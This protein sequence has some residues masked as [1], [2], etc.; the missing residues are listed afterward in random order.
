MFINCPNILLQ[1]GFAQSLFFLLLNL[2][3]CQPFSVNVHIVKSAGLN[4][5]LGRLHIE[6]AELQCA[7][8]TCIDVKNSII[9]L[10]PTWLSK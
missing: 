9:L 6:F 10:I 7:K 1:V 2:E 5:L 3:I 4:L 8:E